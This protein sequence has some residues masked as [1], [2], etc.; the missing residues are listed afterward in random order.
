MQQIKTIYPATFKENYLSRNTYSARRIP[1]KV[2]YKINKCLRCGLVFSSP[3]ISSEKI[4][5][6]YKVS[7]CN[8]EDQIPYLNK[9][10]FNIIKKIKSDLPKKPKVLEVGCG[11]GFFLKAL[12][13]KGFTKKVFGVEPSSKMVS[14]ASADLRKKIKIDFFKH[15]LFPKETFDIILCFHTL[16][17]MIDPNEFI[18]G[19]H[20]L[21][22]ENGYVVTVV[23]DTGSLSVKIFGEN[24][25]IFDIE[26]IYLFNKKTLRKIFARNSFEVIKVF[27]LV[28]SYPLNYWIEMSGFPYVVKKFVSVIVSWLGIAKIS[29]SIPAGNIGIIAK[30]EKS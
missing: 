3:I 30:K 2:H 11:N 24:S 19:A 6:F 4:S 13:E 18:M 10:Y 29:F 16:D 15:G 1:D 21:L 20:S 14:S 12:K 17:H 23:H 28:N 26:H 8:Y 27:N 22:K 25:P 9:T 7:L 5:S